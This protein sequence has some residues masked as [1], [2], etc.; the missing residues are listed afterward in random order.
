MD[1]RDFW[2]LFGISSFFSDSWDFL[3]F[4]SRIFGIL[5]IFQVIRTLKLLGIFGLCLG[6]L[7]SLLDFSGFP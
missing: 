7:G 2:D 4:S 1:V 5:G 3:H 6:F